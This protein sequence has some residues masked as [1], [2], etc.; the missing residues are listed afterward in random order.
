MPGVKAGHRDAVR[1][2]EVQVLREGGERGFR[3][4][5]TGGHMLPQHSDQTQ[6]AGE[7]NQCE[8][9]LMLGTPYFGGL[10]GLQIQTEVERL[11]CKHPSSQKLTPVVYN[12]V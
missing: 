10:Q 3:P 12:T 7:G 4:W 9:S 11:S 8:C 2:H 5:G 1:S 6:H